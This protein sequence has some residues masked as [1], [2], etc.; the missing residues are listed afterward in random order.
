MHSKDPTDESAIDD[1]DSDESLLPTAGRSSRLR[2]LSEF[3]ATTRVGLEFNSAVDGPYFDRN[4]HNG[5]IRARHLQSPALDN[6][7][8][9][10]PVKGVYFDNA[11]GNSPR[12]RILAAFL[13]S[14]IDED[15]RTDLSASWGIETNSDEVVDQHKGIVKPFKG[16]P[17][18]DLSALGAM[19]HEESDDIK[20]V[21]AAYD[22]FLGVVNSTIYN[23]LAPDRDYKRSMVD[24]EKLESIDHWRV[25][26]LLRGLAV[27][28]RDGVTKAT[29]ANKTQSQMSCLAAGSVMLSQLS[30]DYC[31]AEIMGQIHTILYE[32]F[33]GALFVTAR[34]QPRWASK[35]SDDFKTL[36]DLNG[37]ISVLGKCYCMTWIMYLYWARFDE[38]SFTP[39]LVEVHQDTSWLYIKVKSGKSEG[40][41]RPAGMPRELAANNSK[42]R[43][44]L[45]PWL[46][47]IAA[48]LFNANHRAWKSLLVVMGLLV[49]VVDFV[50]R[51]MM[52]SG[53]HPTLSWPYLLMSKFG[54]RSPLSRLRSRS[55]QLAGR[56]TLAALNPLLAGS[57][58][59]MLEELLGTT[60][61]LGALNHVSF[62][63]AF[64]TGY[65]DI[66][67]IRA[68][69]HKWLSIRVS[70]DARES[71]LNHIKLVEKCDPAGT[72]SDSAGF[73][74]ITTTVFDIFI[75]H[76]WLLNIPFY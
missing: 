18:L 62:R 63:A 30:K 4:P 46:I 5:R 58:G 47:A 54:E 67:D 11:N 7:A 43:A 74:H 76:R 38:V 31:S 15:G 61:S 39:A 26:A 22:K 50:R 45:A 20:V 33:D 57:F 35:V 51:R 17:L 37:D 56:L 59:I 24:I 28:L 19:D 48:G 73:V 16:L 55:P 8:T 68:V 70:K 9:T 34:R 49:L 29:N 32:R 36:I 60:A 6:A 2:R 10:E 27:A 25:V 69:G 64:T 21:R 13:F 75:N 52:G 42:N 40:E 14:T 1:L 23:V 41:V 53:K 44:A 3:I 66:E 12:D 71:H 65:L 72:W